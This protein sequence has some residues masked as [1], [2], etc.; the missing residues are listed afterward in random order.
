MDI[1]GLDQVGRFVSR[2]LMFCHNS[3][4]LCSFPRLIAFRSSMP[5]SNSMP[6]KELDRDI[7]EAGQV[8]EAGGEARGGTET[9]EAGGGA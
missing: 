8:G 2:A 9:G 5:W 6:W 3:R 4:A 1:A 7:S